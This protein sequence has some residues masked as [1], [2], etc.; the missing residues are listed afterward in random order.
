MEV[1]LSMS[2][3]ENILTLCVRVLNQQNQ[4]LG[5]TAD[6]EV[7]SQNTSDSF[8]IKHSDASQDTDV[9]GIPGFSQVRV[10][11]VT[12]TSKECLQ[13]KFTVCAAH[14]RDCDGCVR[15]RCADSTAATGAGGDTIT[16][17]VT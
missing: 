11:E 17:M 2:D 10:Y 14:Q 6:V 3:A 1:E 4:P 7:Q 5:R 16:I 8:R 9:S 15:I 13:A 12:V